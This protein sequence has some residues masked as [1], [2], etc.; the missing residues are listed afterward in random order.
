[1]YAENRTKDIWRTK[2]HIPGPNG[3]PCCASSALP[4]LNSYFSNVAR[5]CCIASSEILNL[6]SGAE[7]VLHSV[8]M[9][10]LMRSIKSLGQS[11]HF[12][13]LVGMLEMS[14]RCSG[15]AGIETGKLLNSPS[16]SI[17]RPF[18]V[19]DS[20]SSHA[21]AFASSVLAARNVDSDAMSHGFGMSGVEI[22]GILRGGMLADVSDRLDNGL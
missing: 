21:F 12:S 9:T 19:A 22:R 6:N 13:V 18:V 3:E 7:G 2:L 16:I 8:P 20:C 14:S 15:S 1:M 11:K 10:C 5:L 17:T 4:K